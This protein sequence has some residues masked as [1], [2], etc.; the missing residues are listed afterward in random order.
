MALSLR[1]GDTVSL[2]NATGVAA[3]PGLDIAKLSIGEEIAVSTSNSPCQTK[4]CMAADY[5]ARME[6]LFFDDFNN[7]NSDEWQKKVY[8]YARAVADQQNMLKVADVG[9]GSGYKLMKFFGDLHTVGYD[10]EPTLTKLKATYPSKAWK[11]SNFDGAVETADLVISSD[12]I[13]HIPEPDAF[14]NYLLKFNA[15]YYVV[16]TPDRSLGLVAT[17]PPS[18]RAH[19]R[20][21]THDELAQYANTHGF[22]VLDERIYRPQKSMWLLMERSAK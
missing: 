8:Q 5:K 10:L 18:N 19:V 20:E 22:R 9:C 1:R 17:G 11:E 2:R 15:K 4:Y 7:T 16:S 13:E 6:N 21:W 12:V 3:M 14:M